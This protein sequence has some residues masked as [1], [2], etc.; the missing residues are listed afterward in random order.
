MKSIFKFTLMFILAMIVSAC[1]TDPVAPIVQTK[2]VAVLPPKELIKAC[3]A[4]K[5]PDRVKYN[6]AATWKE[7]EEI[8]VTY[9]SDLLTDLTKCSDT[10]ENIRAWKG[11]QEQNYSKEE[12]KK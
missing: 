8:L 10:V 9:S 5:P 6:S 4:H 12:E 11:T 7:K 3:S 1:A 2:R